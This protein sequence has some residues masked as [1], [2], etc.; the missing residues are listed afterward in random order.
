MEQLRQPQ[1]GLSTLLKL[2]PIYL[3][4]SQGQMED[5]ISLLSELSGTPIVI[6]M[7]SKSLDLEP[8]TPEIPYELRIKDLIKCLIED[9][10]DDPVLFIPIIDLHIARLKKAHLLCVAVSAIIQNEWE[11]GTDLED[12]GKF[13]QA[14]ALE[15][16]RDNPMPRGM[17]QALLDT[18]P[19]NQG[20]S[21]ADLLE[22]IFRNAEAT[23]TNE[24]VVRKLNNLGTSGDSIVLEPTEKT[25][26]AETGLGRIFSR[27]RTLHDIQRDWLSDEELWLTIPED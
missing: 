18:A 15:P 4:L 1:G 23:D 22:C 2:I 21:P 25:S 16:H 20:W 24:D 6:E 5:L 13:L 27:M 14:W 11:G 10:E 3:Q 7:T 17:L 9:P 8:L 26:D 19:N 12:I